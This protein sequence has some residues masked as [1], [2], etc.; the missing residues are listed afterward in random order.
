MRDLS[1]EERQM[2]KTAREQLPSLGEADTINLSME[3]SKVK[4]THRSRG[5]MKITVKLSADEAVAFKNFSQVKP[6]EVDDETFWKQ[7]F[8][9]G[10]NA[11]TMH[12]HEMVEKHK[13]SLEYQEAVPDELVEISPPA[14]EEPQTETSE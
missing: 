14:D 13:S 10:C 2:M 1:E 11:M 7:I 8:L 3:D 5:R 9:T 6:P 12:L 4:I